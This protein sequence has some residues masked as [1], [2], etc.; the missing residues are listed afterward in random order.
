MLFSTP[1]PRNVFRWGSSRGADTDEAGRFLQSRLTFFVRMMAAFFAVM[2]VAGIV[3]LAL[4]APS[5]LLPVHRHPSKLLNLF[6][7]VV[8]GATWL[9][10]RGGPRSNRVLRAIDLGSVLVLS[11]SVGAGVALA[12]G[13]YHL[14]FGALLIAI[15]PLFLRAALVPSAALWTALVGLVATPAI[16]LGGYLQVMANRSSGSF[17][18]PAVLVSA[19]V[20]WC[21]SSTAVTAIISHV[22]YGLVVQVQEATRLGQYTLRDKIGEGGMGAVYRAEHAMLRRP[23]AVKLLQPSRVGA[24]SLARF[25]REVQ[26]TSQLSHPNTIS[27]YD[28]GRTP[29]G[30]F[31][32]AMEYLEGRTLDALVAASGPQ[33]PGR[34]VHILA[35]VAGALR[36]AHAVGLIH[37]DVKPSNV[38]LC[39]RGGIPEFIKVIDFGLV[40]RFDGGEDVAVTRVD[41]IAGTPLFMA[42]ECLVR[43]EAV[44]AAIDVYALGGVAYFLLTGSPPFT[45]STV[46]EVCGHH[47]HTAPTPPSERLGHSIPLKLEALVMRCLEKD[48]KARPSDGELCALLEGCRKEI[49]F[50][51]E[52][53]A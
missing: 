1:P 24:E 4:V 5:Y 11:V 42:P 19:I 3:I 30:V 13:G 16:V 44:G 50:D 14:E 2:Y 6:L 51:V 45:G 25:E 49:P 27:I 18:T 20:L 36:E 40:K 37:R 53:A 48:P 39:T 21:A 35:Q 31:Y 41:A 46:V 23:T 47:L 9:Y 22:I 17:V 34:V 32:Y 28:Y 8:F 12:P 29:E 15:L 43:P 10:L 38:L 33:A 52:R 7:V 26:L